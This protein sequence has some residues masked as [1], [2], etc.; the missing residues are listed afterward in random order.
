MIMISVIIPVYNAEDY[1]DTPLRSLLKQSFQNF[2]VILVNDG[3]T[4]NSVDVIRK[5]IK[6]NTR[7][8][9][10]NQK[11]SGPGSARNKGVSEAKGQYISFLDS[12]DYFEP[13]FLEE[14]YKVAVDEDADIVVCDFDKVNIDGS[15]IKVYKSKLK[16]T[17]DNITAFKDIL[18][19][20]NLTSISA[21]KIFRKKLFDKVT[22]PTGIIINEDVAT[23]YRLIL[24]ANKVAFV[25]KVLFH[26]VQ[27]EGSSMNGFNYNKLIDRLKVAE[28]IENHLNQE[29]LLPKY[30]EVYNVYYLLNVILS[31]AIQICKFSKNWQSHIDSF[32][33]EID[34]E[35]FTFKNIFFLIKKHKKKMLALLALKTNKFLFKTLTNYI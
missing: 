8:K 26:Y 20:E 33:N 2:E 7:F 11:N 18:Q 6:T 27:I 5:I 13:N 28:I 10:I 25:S 31:G 29:K 34:E 19:S 9:I 17:I 21:N 14:M 23:I 16:K 12:D 4:D 1:I 30:K 3:S 15:S 35:I 24:K 32:T 22:Y